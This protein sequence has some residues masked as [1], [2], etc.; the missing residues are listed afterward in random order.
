MSRTTTIT[1][2]AV[3]FALAIPGAAGAQDLRNP[4]QRYPDVTYQDYRNADRRDESAPAHVITIPRTRV[5][6]VEQTGFEWGDAA[7]GGAGAVAALLAAGGLI[8]T[9][10]P[11]RGA[12]AH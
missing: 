2:T 3:A 1:A 8:L 6:E 10:R 9:I 11:R 5:V 4:D 12:A 7:I